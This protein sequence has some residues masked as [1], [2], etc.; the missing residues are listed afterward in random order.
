MYGLF[1][2]AFSEKTAAVFATQRASNRD[3][4]RG[5]E[6]GRDA[7]A[8]RYAAGIR[9][10]EIQA[11]HDGFRGARALDAFEMADGVLRN[12]FAPPRDGAEP[13]LT[14][15]TDQVGKLVA[16]VSDDGR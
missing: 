4:L 12:G 14:A 11:G 13:R 9:A 7:V 8:D 5:R 1:V 3:V 6:G 2:Q 15:S 10:A 16:H